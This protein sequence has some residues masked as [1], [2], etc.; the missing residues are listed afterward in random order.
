MPVYIAEAEPYR[1]EMVLWL[2]LPDDYI[3]GQEL[4]DPQG[5]PLSFSGTLLRSMDAPLVGAP[6]RPQR[7]R[8]CAAPLAMELRG[9]VPDIEVVVAPTPELDSVIAQMVA[10]MPEGGGGP[11]YFEHGRVGV[12]AVAALFR[13]AAALFRSA[14]WKLAQD[15][16]ALRLDI[17]AL[18]VEGACVSIIGA[19]EESLGLVIF[20]S[21]LAMERFLARMEAG[22]GPDA[23]LD[24]GTTTLSLNFERGADLPAG[25]RREAAEHGWPVA[26][27]AAYPWAQHRDRDGTMRPLDAR[28]V[29]IVTA[30]A[31]GLAAFFSRHGARFAQASVEP[32]GEGF[33]DAGGVETW[34]AMPYEA[35]GPP[36]SRA[37][38]ASGPALAARAAELHRIDGRLVEGMMEL[39]VRRFADTW[40]RSARGIAEREGVIGLVVPWLVY[41]VL[42]DGKP[43]AHWLTQENDSRLS[44]TERTW[45]GAQQA[46]WLSVWEVLA[47]EPGCGLKLRDLLTGE[48]RE[49]QEVGASK[50]LV[51]RSAMLARVVD[52]EGL[53]LLCG[54][55]ARPLPPREAAGVVGHTG[56]LLR[57]KGLDPRDRLHEEQMGRYLISRWEDA[58]A[59]LE[60]RPVA[61]PRVQNTD[62]DDLLLTVDRFA[63][64]P[65]LRSEIEARLATIE[66]V[67]PL[68][69]GA[70]ERGYLFERPGSPP[71][72]AL[73]VT[74]LGSV[75]IGEGKLRVE[76]NSLARADSDPRAYRSGPR[77][78][79]SP[80]CPRAYR[81]LSPH[82]QG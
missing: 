78:A 75:R 57:R 13:A 48:V 30:C 26:S 55:H 23:R 14:P 66:G 22:R 32:V 12:A 6:R 65:S 70:S 31:N 62:G 35:G 67:R 79:D 4:I 7:I 9:A 74:L 54:S 3:V 63:F 24:M 17:P 77:R 25:M 18:G 33:T 72:G 56:A 81:P 45:L 37:G 73:Q 59:E 8:V 38:R 34:L 58:L 39:A 10:S 49:V 21:H 29:G 53:S 1:P 42:F 76:T 52:Y 11:S 5:T 69:G 41:Q 43:L 46:A 36:G 51:V 80:S 68:E 2:E 27:P 19:L 16:Q 47:V 71:H 15:S 61:L 60:G 50:T 82:R 64:D 44:D 28:D 20:P 40:R